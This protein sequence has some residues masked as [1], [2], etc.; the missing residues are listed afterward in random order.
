[1]NEKN[2]FSCD[3]LVLGS[4]FAGLRAASAA[5]RMGASVVV[6]EKGPRATPDIL[7]F[8]VA[9]EKDDSLEIYETDLQKSSQSIS[10]RNLEKV[11]VKNAKNELCFLEEVGLIFDKKPNGEYDVLHTLGSTYPRLVHYKAMTGI[12]GSR[13]MARD[14]KKHGVKFQQFIFIHKLLHKNG[15]IDGAVGI[16]I[17]SGEFITYFAKAIVLAT[18]GCGAIYDLT[19]YPKGITGD[20]F[21]LAYKAGAEI[22]DMEFM[23]FEPCVFV[24]PDALKGKVIPTTLLRAGAQL[25]NSSDEDILSKHGLNRE[26][27]QK[28]DLAR[29]MLTE[30]RSGK[31]GPHGGVFYDVS[32]LPR[33]RVVED[34]AIFYKPALAAGIDLMKDPAEVMP[35]AHT[36]LG[37]V[38]INAQCETTLSG[39]YAAGEVAGGFYGANRMGGSAGIE[40]LVFGN[41]AGINAAKYALSLEGYDFSEIPELAKI[42]L[43][44]LENLIHRE[45]PVSSSNTRLSSI[46]EETRKIMVAK[47]NL[48]K[49]GHELEE[50]SNRIQEL[51]KELQ[52]E[53]AV[54]AKDLILLLEC[55]NMLDVAMMIIESSR[56]RKE[57]RGAFYRDDFTEKN[58]MN[59]KGNIVVRH[60]SNGMEFQF[61]PISGNSDKSPQNPEPRRIY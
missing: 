8:N 17:R 21:V 9:V 56:M 30:I 16:D 12:E 28:Y 40:T 14:C 25:K 7:G 2:I 57:S 38:R 49:N 50:A 33:K 3:V 46:Q 18:G 15:K 51:Q 27:V 4:G 44:R 11:L 41:I 60:T 36:A 47:V 5:A 26:A 55:R 53:K 61:Q 58:D 52:T 22:I 24:Y 29:A 59:W 54:D 6:V 1:M 20:G 43:A 31:A 39:L 37:G 45:V 42:E 13:L 34:H 23:Q 10:N 35:A 48:I 32:M 19:T